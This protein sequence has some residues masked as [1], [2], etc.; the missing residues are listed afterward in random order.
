MRKVGLL[1]LSDIRIAQSNPK[2]GHFKIIQLEV[3]ALDWVNL[4]YD[5]FK[6]L[7]FHVLSILEFLACWLVT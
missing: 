4:V 3:W 1:N 7:T 2:L 6:D 5:K